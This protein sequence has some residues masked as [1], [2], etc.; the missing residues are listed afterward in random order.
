MPHRQLCEWGDGQVTAVTDG[1]IADVIPQVAVSATVVYFL[2]DAHLGADDAAGEARKA[3]VLARLADEITAASGTVVILGD[4]FDFGFSYGNY[5]SPGNGQGIAFLGRLHAAGLRVLYFGGNHD[6]WYGQYLVR[7]FGVEFFPDAAA[8][9]I[10][11]VRCFVAHGD[12]LAVGEQGYRLLKRLLRSPV[13]S[14]LYRLIPPAWGTALAL[15]C[16]RQSRQHGR[17]RQ[18]PDPEPL[19]RAAQQLLALGYDAVVLGHAHVPALRTEQGKAYLNTGDLNEHFSYGVWR[20][21][22]WQLLDAFTGREW[23]N[24]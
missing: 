13:S 5:V 4:L 9:V 19:A 24:G 21:G 8:V 15:W 16:S 22:S 6:C 17:D 2:S 11:G 20:N 12:G 23:I 7:E 18:Q 1:N 3:E 10:N 14:A